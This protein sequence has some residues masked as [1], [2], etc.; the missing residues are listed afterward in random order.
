MIICSLTSQ[1]STK[2]ATPLL[3]QTV[4][5]KTTVGAT[6]FAGFTASTGGLS[7][8]HD[9]LNWSWVA[10][11][12]INWSWSAESIPLHGPWS[13]GTGG[14]FS[15]LALDS[16]RNPVIS[17]YD[18]IQRAL[19]VM[20]CGNV[21]CSSVNTAV[22]V[23]NTI[24]NTFYTS[25]K[26]DSAGNPVIS[27]Y[28]ERNADL[29]L[30]RCGNPTCSSGNT[31]VTLDSAGSVGQFSS[32]VLDSSG[33]PVIS[34]YDATN[35]DLK[36][37]HCGNATC[38]AGGTIWTVDGTG[39]VGQFSS[40]ALNSS[41]YPIISYYDATNQDLKLVYC[42][43]TTCT[44][45]GGWQT[46]DSTGNV[47]QHTS[48]KLDSSGNPVISYY[49]QTN[50]S[51]KLVKCG[52]PTCSSGNTI[53]FVDRNAADV[54][55]Y[56]SLALDSKDNPVISYY[57][58]TNRDVKLAR[59]GNPTCSSG[60]TLQTLDSAG[61]V[62]DHPSLALDSQGNAF[63]SY[64][65]GS[66]RKL[67]LARG[68]RG[69]VAPTGGAVSVWGDNTYGQLN[70]PAGL[71]GISKIATGY[72]HTLALKG[73]G[74]VVAWGY[75]AY[76]QS[77]VPAG[78]T[79]VIALAAGDRHS[80]ALKGDGTVVAWGE[81]S[82]GQ[83]TVPAGLNNVVAI[84]VGAFHNLALKG[85]GTVVAWGSNNAGESTVPAG[86]N[87]VAAIAAGSGF[88]VALKRDGTVLAWGDNTYSQ[89]NVPAGLS[90]IKAIAAGRL[91]TLALKGDNTVVA[92]GYTCCYQ[93]AVPAGLSGVSAL[94]GGGYHSIV[95][96]SDGTV[97]SWGDNS[98]T[99]RN[100]PAG[101]GGV[102][103]LS[104]GGFHTVLLSQEGGFQGL[105]AVGAAMAS[106][107]DVTATLLPVIEEAPPAVVDPASLTQRI[108]LPL[109]NHAGAAASGVDTVATAT[110]PA[111]MADRTG[112]TATLP[113]TET[114][115]V[116][117]S[118]LTTTMTNTVV[119]ETVPVSVPV[120]AVVTATMAISSQSAI[121][122]Q[123]VVEPTA[124]TTTLPVTTA[125]TAVGSELASN[126]PVTASV[127]LTVET[128]PVVTATMAISSQNAITTPAVVEPIAV[129]T[130]Q[131]DTAGAVNAAADV[132]S[133][134]PIT[135]TAAQDQQLFLP[136]I[137]NAGDLAG[138]ALGSLDNTTLLTIGLLIL[139]GGILWVRQRRI[140]R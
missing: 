82:L 109:V 53:Q 98:A 91:H 36:V 93:I 64:W 4:N 83:G 77:T 18:D 71:S 50:R 15:S 84:A 112:I 87:N 81:N 105:D 138:T 89:R 33:N 54:G 60:N 32:L 1:N 28:D 51:L 65:D 99:Q 95:L 80:L 118:P 113:V 100:L 52:N 57:D 96:K 17:Y 2:P 40:L 125:A 24:G 97:V 72:R 49:D 19:M 85:D 74:T 104:A 79:G 101:L 123:T 35:Q 61:N 63:V 116:T 137:S 128:A 67:K 94:A 117:P 37:V 23:D 76:G 92:W 34:Y 78:L 134:A 7:L 27:Y 90:G 136:F 132:A 110:Q 58:P 38:T 115:M 9:I 129:T 127:A 59:C 11:N 41:G 56:T 130:T 55:W 66:N 10:D 119:T 140:Q 103:A 43:N 114:M 139:I 26:L 86:L 121:T 47:G 13:V 44:A 62:G 21:I 30:A 3:T 120:P 135:D 122:T 29:K 102:A 42:G 88:S 111:V 20:H 131:S 108:F 39:N 106:T 14:Q 31:V 70:M 124:V 22:A 133:G 16:Q 5:L 46:V 126:A 75:N 107:T 12:L 69:V 8:D 68:S 25:L 48:L 73:D 45:G 6:A